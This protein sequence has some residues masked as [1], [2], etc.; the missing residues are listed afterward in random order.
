[1]PSIRLVHGSD[2]SNSVWPRLVWRELDRSSSLSARTAPCGEVLPVA[3]PQLRPMTTNGL[4]IGLHLVLVPAVLVAE[5]QDSAD[6]IFG[7]IYDD[8][9]MLQ[10]NDH[11]HYE[12]PSI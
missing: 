11:Q 6:W 4:S 8:E 12:S 7:S 3:K 1:M 10:L 5:R 9:R 2:I